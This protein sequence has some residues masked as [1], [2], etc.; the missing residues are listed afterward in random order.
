VKV[1]KRLKNRV[2]SG[3]RRSAGARPTRI[4]A[5]HERPRLARLEGP[6]DVLVHDLDYDEVRLA[7]QRDDPSRLEHEVMEL[8][9]LF[10]H[11]L[12]RVKGAQRP[13]RARQRRHEQ[14]SEV[15]FGAASYGARTTIA[16]RAVALFER[17]VARSV[18]RAPCGI[19]RGRCQVKFVMPSDPMRL[20]S[21]TPL[22]QIVRPRRRS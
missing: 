5:S 22:F 12:Q 3:E 6:D 20:L 9:H 21:F 11:A 14:G 16:R 8:W 13:C 18:R 10:A 1:L 17:S 2:V 19:F 4:I 15:P 7:P